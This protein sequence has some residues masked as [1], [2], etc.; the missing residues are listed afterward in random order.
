MEIPLIRL[1]FSYSA[2]KSWNINK[3]KLFNRFYKSL[4]I[5]PEGDFKT[6][7]D[8]RF[9]AD[10]KSLKELFLYFSRFV[11]IKILEKCKHLKYLDLT[12]TK[13]KTAIDLSDNDAL[14]TIIFDD[15]PNLRSVYDNPYIKKAT[16]YNFQSE[17]LT[18]LREMSSL[19]KLCILN[20][21]ILSSLE[22]LNSL[23]N[24]RIVEVNNCKNLSNVNA[25]SNLDRK[26]TLR[27][28]GDKIYREYDLQPEEVEVIEEKFGPDRIDTSFNRK[29][30]NK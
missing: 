3:T 19:E 28:N 25:F 14:E 17:N 7:A 24:L 21:K 8:L 16:I 5:Y 30:K 9:L 1:P 10:L 27:I 12:K 29:L 26:I 20:S 22:G 18:E 13:A 4:E 11:D 15:Q 6:N 23:H 2:G